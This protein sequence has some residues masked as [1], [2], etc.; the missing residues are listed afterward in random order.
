[1]EGVLANSDTKAA[2]LISS[3]PGCFI[4][5]ADIAWLDSAQSKEEVTFNKERFILQ[6]DYYAKRLPV[7]MFPPLRHR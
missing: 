6:N 4:A 1:M 2:V 5:G 7:Y 3:K